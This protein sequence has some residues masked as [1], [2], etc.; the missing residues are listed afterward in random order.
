VD[1]DLVQHIAL[2]SLGPEVQI[3]GWNP[4]STRPTATAIVPPNIKLLAFFLQSYESTAE[5]HHHGSVME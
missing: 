1:L 5:G 3:K 4:H 2:G